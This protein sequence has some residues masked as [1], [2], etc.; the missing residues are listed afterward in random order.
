MDVDSPRVFRLATEVDQDEF[1]LFLM[2]ATTP[3]AIGSLIVAS[4]NTLLDEDSW[5]NQFPIGLISG[6]IA[7][8]AAL[9]SAIWI[10]REVGDAEFLVFLIFATIPVA[11]GGLVILS[12][13]WVRRYVLGHLAITGVVL[14]ILVLLGS[15]IMGIW[16]AKDISSQEGWIFLSFSSSPISLG[17]LILTLSIRAMSMAPC[18]EPI[19]L[20]P[21][22]HLLLPDDTSISCPGTKP[23]CLCMYIDHHFLF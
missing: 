11:I 3:F 20:S 5:S 13:V 2:F 14:G 15:L 6:V 9:A 18:R 23:V 17:L 4:A 7:I 1:W 12:D 16:A 8:I 21:R 10:A 19:T 22:T